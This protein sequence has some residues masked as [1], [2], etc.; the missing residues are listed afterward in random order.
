MYARRTRWTGVGIGLGVLVGTVLPG[1][2]AGQSRDLDPRVPTLN[3][4]VVDEITRAPVEGAVVSIEGHR[5]AVMTDAG[6][7]F[8]LSGFEPG[9]QLLEVRQFGY[10]LLRVEIVPPPYEDVL[11]EVPLAPA[12]IQLEG[13]TAVV[14]GLAEATRRIRGRRNAAPV[15]SRAYDQDALVRSG[16]PTALDFLARNTPLNPETCFSRG[17]ASL[18]VLRRGRMVRPRVYVDEMPALA[19]LDDLSRYA[20]E[21]LYLIEVFCFGT[22][23]RAY[24]FDWMDRMT[25]RPRA[26]IPVSLW[27]C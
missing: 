26:L 20:P 12:P 8:T 25:A 2:V 3:G 16:A 17:F 23:I 24:T 13:V 22:E 10:Q 6:G 9:R 18:C 21:E 15:A 1:G 5:P 4:I 19:G 7:R 11:V 27:S 14:D